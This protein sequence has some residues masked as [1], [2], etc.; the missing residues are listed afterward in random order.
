MH[1][2][3]GGVSFQRA[4]AALSRRAGCP[5]ESGFFMISHYFYIKKLPQSVFT[6]RE[7]VIYAVSACV[8]EIKPPVRTEPADAAG[9]RN[10]W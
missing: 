3:P 1:F 5:T 10:A 7:F 2:L 9:E 4:G 6:L 8:Q